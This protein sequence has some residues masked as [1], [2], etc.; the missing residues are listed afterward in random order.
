V[1][2]NVDPQLLVVGG[3]ALKAAALGVLA[4]LGRGPMIFN[5]GHGV[6]PEVPVEHVSE[7]ISTV[8]GW[9]P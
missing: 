5:L 8:R 2:G 4:A 7:L 9:R 6:V 1:Q 3:A